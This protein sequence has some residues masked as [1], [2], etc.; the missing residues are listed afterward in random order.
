MQCV[1]QACDAVNIVKTGVRG[2]VTGQQHRDSVAGS[3]VVQRIQ[4]DGESRHVGNAGG[5]HNAVGQDSD[6]VAGPCIAECI[7]QAGDSAEIVET[8]VGCRVT[9]QQRRNCVAAFVQVHHAQPVGESRCVVQVRMGC[10]AGSQD[11]RPL[12]VFGPMQCPQQADGAE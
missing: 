2:G 10:D 6:C 12:A 7:Q 5:S 11:T 4:Q 3:S 1:Q 9:G 8:D